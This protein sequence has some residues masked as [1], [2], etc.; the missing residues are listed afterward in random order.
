MPNDIPDW[1]NPGQV[2]TLNANIGVGSIA[3]GSVLLIPN[4]GIGVHTYLYE[5]ELALTAVAGCVLN[6]D[7]PFGTTRCFFDGGQTRVYVVRFDG[8]DCGAG[9]DVY[10]GIAGAALA[11]GG[12]HVTARQA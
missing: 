2:P 5:F 6:L 11:A 12:G 7:C 10:L 9:A 8:L 1:S 4:G 3:I